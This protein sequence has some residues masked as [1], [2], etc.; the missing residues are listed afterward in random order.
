MKKVN[1]KFTNEEIEL[2]NKLR[3][4]TGKELV[5]ILHILG[6]T[7]NRYATMV[8]PPLASASGINYYRSAKKIPFRIIM[9][10]IEQYP[11]QFLVNL[12]EQKVTE[13]SQNKG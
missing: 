11:V 5:Q 12:L 7:M 6:I 2:I 4:M 10:L 9:P 1:Q 13:L 8:K 3:L